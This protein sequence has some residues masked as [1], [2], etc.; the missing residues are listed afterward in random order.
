MFHVA[1]CAV[2]GVSHDRWRD[3]EHTRPAAYCH[4]CHAS[5]MRRT[6]PEYR[7]LSMWEKLKSCARSYANVYQRRGKLRREPCAACGSPE[8]QKHHPDYANPLIVV[9]LC[10][11]CHTVLHASEAA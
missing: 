1:K 10:R 3:A 8:A 4:S 7:Q 11:P 2:C 6:R 9:W 5:Y